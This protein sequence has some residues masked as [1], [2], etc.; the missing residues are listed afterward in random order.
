MGASLFSRGEIY[1]L[2]FFT[3]TFFFFKTRSCY[4]S[5]YANGASSLSPFSGLQPIQQTGSTTVDPSWTSNPWCHGSYRACAGV[6]V[7]LFVPYQCPDSDFL[8]SG[9]APSIIIDSSSQ[10]RL[11]LHSGTPQRAME[12]LEI[13]TRYLSWE[14]APTA[15]K[16]FVVILG[17]ATQFHF[18][19]KPTFAL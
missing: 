9:R 4:Q 16:H 11:R 12:P 17:G 6:W 1:V 7:R 19:G 2:V 14:K 8:R 3:Y 10:R 18:G 15:Q 13:A 5:F